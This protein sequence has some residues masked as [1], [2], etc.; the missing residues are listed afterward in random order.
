MRKPL[1][2]TL[3]VVAALLATLGGLL[4]WLRVDG[5]EEG[6]GYGF[7]YA[8]GHWWDALLWSTRPPT[9]FLILMVLAAWSLA[10]IAVRHPRA[11]ARLA[12]PVAVL[13]AVPVSLGST[14]PFGAF[15]RP[16][17]SELTLVPDVGLW[18]ALGSLTLATLATSLGV[19]SRGRP[20]AEPE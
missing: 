19:S 6:H 11:A 2:L 9:V 18:A 4:D 3:L 7:L 8:G 5:A 15:S 10:G 20:A 12:L 13:L 17:T 1:V 16:L 14:L